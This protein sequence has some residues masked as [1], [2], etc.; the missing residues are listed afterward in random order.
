MSGDL[1]KAARFGNAYAPSTP[2]KLRQMPFSYT[3][4]L[5]AGGATAA[6]LGVDPSLGVALA[7]GGALAGRAAA[8]PVQS[9]LRNYL[10][11]SEGQRGAM[12]NYSGLGINPGMAFP[13]TVGMFSTLQQQPPE[14]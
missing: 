5:A 12:P 13:A 9:T 3:V 1:E 7:A 4:G 6:A 8:Q 14:E 2:D 10:L 11:S